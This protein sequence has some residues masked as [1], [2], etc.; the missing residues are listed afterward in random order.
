MINRETVSILRVIRPKVLGPNNLVELSYL[1]LAG[2]SSRRAA[3][4][5][6]HERNIYFHL[7]LIRYKLIQNRLFLDINTYCDEP[8]YNNIS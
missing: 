7:P 5:L 8:N 4:R 1:Y 3:A 2:K 6:F